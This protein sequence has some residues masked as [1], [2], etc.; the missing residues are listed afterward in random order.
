MGYEINVAKNGTH[1]FATADRSIGWCM[2]KCRQIYNQ[3]KTAFPESDGYT[4]SVT[5]YQNIG[6]SVDMEELEM[7]G[8]LK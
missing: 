6:T 7:T 5:N 2:T 8:E 4:I 1:H 3:L